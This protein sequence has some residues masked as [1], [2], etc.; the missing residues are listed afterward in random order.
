MP[1]E[2][3]TDSFEGRIPS[4]TIFVDKDG[5]WFHHGALILNRDLIA[6]FY[7]SLH[8]DTDGRYLIKL[9]DQICRLEV[10]DTPFV[11][12]RTDLISGSSPGQK[13]R[14]VLRIID[15]TEE[16]LDPET[17]W[18]GPDNMM[19]CRIRQGRFK[20]RF[21]RAGYYQLARHIKE[22]SETGRYFLPLSGR[23]HFIAEAASPGS[24]N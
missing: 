7:Q 19:Y 4:C 15:D 21:L 1:Q 17:L 20:A 2:K 3:E 23:K 9:K 16:E 6:L 12:V 24:R 11:I 10:E 13:D 22:D 14:V 5:Q 8:V 18:I